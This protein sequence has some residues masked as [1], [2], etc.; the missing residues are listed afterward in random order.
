MSANVQNRKDIR[1]AFAAL[2][3]TA[4]VGTGL[5]AQKV[6]PYRVSDFKG[7]YSVVAVTS[8]KANRSKQ[9]QV[10]RVSSGVNLEAHTF[11][12][13]SAPSVEATNNPAAGNNV[14]INVPSTTDFEVGDVVTLEDASHTERATVNLVTANVSIRVATL[15]YSYTAPE[16][17]WWTERDSEDRMDL[18]EKKISDVIMDNDT[19]DTWAQ[20]SF[21][22]DTQQDPVVIGGRDYLHEIF[23]LNFRLHSD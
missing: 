7:R 3:E 10:T 13:Y 6:Y 8:G 4:L 19:N 9:A 1:E 14:T 2:L 18:L 15:A 20:L 12:L 16:V 11:V 22:G 5:P 23:P 21:D 17:F